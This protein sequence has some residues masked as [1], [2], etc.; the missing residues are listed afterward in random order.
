MYYYFEFI[1]NNE[2]LN[3]KNKSE[4]NLFCIWS[5]IYIFV[6]RNVCEFRFIVVF[7]DLYF[8]HYS[9]YTMMKKITKKLFQI[10]KIEQIFVCFLIKKLQSRIL[11]K[12]NF[13]K[14]FITWLIELFRKLLCPKILLLYLLTMLSSFFANCTIHAFYELLITLDFQK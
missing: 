4:S 6:F 8:F 2:L 10:Y 3:L 12:W 14:L 13:F 5:K 11:L 7:I 1:R 9:Q